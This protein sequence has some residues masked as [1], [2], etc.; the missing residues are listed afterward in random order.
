MQCLVVSSWHCTYLSIVLRT[1][2]N[3]TRSFC[4]VKRFPN[5]IWNSILRRHSKWLLYLTITIDTSLMRY[6]ASHK[7]G[8]SIILINKCKLSWPF[9][10]CWWGWQCWNIESKSTAVLQNESPYEKVWSPSQRCKAWVFFKA[11]SFMANACV[12][13]IIRHCFNAFWSCLYYIKCGN[14]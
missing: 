4:A 7:D 5:L 2:I 9:L 12:I 13:D 11:G 6:R 1:S 14:N 10:V 8:G 3:T